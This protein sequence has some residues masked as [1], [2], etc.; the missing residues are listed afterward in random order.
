[1]QPALLLAL[2]GTSYL[3]LA[4]GPGWTRLPIAVLAVL[5]LIAPRRT[6]SFPA[7]T[8]VLDLALVALAMAIAA[9]LIPLPVAVIDVVSPFA[10]PLRAATTL[11]IGEPSWVPLSI[12]AEA[13]S[14][15]LTTVV[16]GILT[17]WVARGMFSAG[18]STRQFCRA[19]GFMAALFATVATVQ[20][21][22]RPGLLMGVVAAAAPNAN[23][24]GPFTNRNHFAA[25]MLMASC[26]AA[27]YLIAHLH[28]HPAYRGRLRDALRHLLA[29]GAL[30]SAICLLIS[31]LALL[32]TLSR[33][34]AAG[35]G[36]AAVG[37]AWL[38]R[39]RLRIERTNLPRVLAAVGTAMLLTAAFV[40]VDG[41][42]ARMQQ[43]FAGAEFDR[44]TIW[45]NSLPVISDFF[46]F[47][48]GAGTYSQAMTHYQ[49]ARIWVGAMHGWA[50]FNNAHSHYVQLFCEGG[51]WLLAPAITA[52]VALMRLGLEAIGADKGEV[53]WLRVG[54][55][56]G[57]GGIALQSVW[58]VP[59]TL[60][61]NAILSGALA[62]LLVFRRDA[63]RAQC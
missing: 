16:L 33:S 44:I 21:A 17:F 27:G 11:S 55:A 15:A 46:V 3:L 47:G 13:T 28:I 62:G 35:L 56:A 22:V 31:I 38:G 39:A 45:R 58:E 10:R 1:M 49:E 43:S 30:L 4:G 48:T 40:D 12:N 37:G 18:R 57:L 34:A 52:A 9:Q 41:W 32:A 51:V 8:R 53:F 7:S 36:F 63:H 26:A 29:S 14:H 5:T 54:A 20:R 50:H 6:L 59:L 25:W 42:L 24:I 2:V 61:A 19:L 23:P 60:P